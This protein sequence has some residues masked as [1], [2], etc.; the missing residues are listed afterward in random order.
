MR[1]PQRTA[2]ADASPASD[3]PLDAQARR[4]AIR[5]TVG[6]LRRR[7]RRIAPS[8]TVLPTGF[9]ALD[10]L[11]HGGLPR[12]RLSALVA[13]PGGG[14]AMLA[15]AVAARRLLAGDRVAVVDP[16]GVFFPPALW[17]LASPPGAADALTA[18]KAAAACAPHVV[19]PP[20]TLTAWTC[21]QLATSGCFSL[22][23]A[24][25]PPPVRTPAVS[26][27]L[28]RAA[29]RG[30]CAL[31]LVQHD[32]TRP[33]PRSA[34]ALRTRWSPEAPGFELEVTALRGPGA[35]GSAAIVLWPAPRETTAP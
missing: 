7:M 9:E 15:V 12:G 18:S 17:S 8:R 5:Q 29:E 1:L 35:G 3:A 31:V 30:G 21:E 27:R 24:L 26:V 32:S 10:A 4:R 25:D 2:T 23:V 13:P 14:A 22:V 6:E 34:V 16:Y 33:P 28:Q 19:R 20:A 11:L